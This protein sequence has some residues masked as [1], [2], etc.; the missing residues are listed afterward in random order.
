MEATAAASR[1]VS[2]PENPPNPWIPRRFRVAARKQETSDTFSIELAD[3]GGEEHEGFS[4][5]P[6]QFNMLYAFGVGES[7][8]SISGDPAAGGQPVHTIRVVGTVTRALGALRRGDVLGVR[9]PFGS[10]WPV[11]EAAGRDVIVV[12]GGIGLAPLRPALHQ[13]F[14]DRARFGRITLLYGARTPRDLLFGDDLDRWSRRRNTGVQVIVDVAGPSWHGNVGVVTSLFKRVHID[15]PDTVALICGPEV[16]M[17]FTA[18]E[19]LQ[20]EVPIDAIHVSLERNMKCA[21]GFCGHCQ[22][23]P[24]FVCKDGPVFPFARVKPWF[25]VREL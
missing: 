8:I 22:Y 25:M 3:A 7:A 16:M 2:A 11:E 4:F 23:G 17:R 15:G 5:R 12:A 18:V 24:A 13:L 6:G 10:A 9:G 19:L 14:A 21:T 1:V 20:R